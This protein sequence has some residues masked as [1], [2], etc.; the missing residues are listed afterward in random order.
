ML[1]SSS[2]VSPSPAMSAAIASRRSPSRMASAMIGLVL[3]D[4]HTH[5]LDATSRRISSAYRKPHTCWQHHAALTGSMR[6]T[7]AARTTTRRI[8]GS[9]PPAWSS[10]PLRSSEP[11]AISQHRRRRPRSAERSPRRRH[12]AEPP[13]ASSSAPSF[14]EVP[15]G[16]PRRPATVRAIDGAV[17]EDDGVLPDGVTVFDD[18]YPGRGQPRP[19]SAPGPA[20]KRRRMPRTTASSSTSTAAGAP[21]STRIS[22]FARR[23]RSTAQKRKPPD[24]SPPRTRPLTCPG[25]RSTSGPPMPRRGCPSTAPSTGCARSTATNPGTTNCAPRRSIAVARP[26]TPTPR[27]IRGCSSDERARPRE[28]VVVAGD[29]HR[30]RATGA[31]RTPPRSARSRA[32]P[33]SPSGG[34]ATGCRES[35]ASPAIAAAARRG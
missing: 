3:D 31:R 15:R 18:E 30:R 29:H 7:A 35:A 12:R 17:T 10:S 33:G 4:Q 9:L 27:T 20:R 1:S 8:P 6:Q 26:C 34:R 16:E 32:R 2:A 14:S 25:T 13:S 19:R 24:G 5:A 22:C 23:S 21:R 11:S 28:P